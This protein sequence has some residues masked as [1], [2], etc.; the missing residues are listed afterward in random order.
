[1][2][3]LGLESSCDETAFAIYGQKEGLMSHNLFSQVEIHAEFGGVVPELAS[4][5]HIRRV[6]P[7]LNQCLKDAGLKIN[8]IS[9]IGYT[10][11]PGLAGALLVGSTFAKALAYAQSIPAIGVHHLEAHLMAV[12]LEE[13][14]PTFPFLTLLV[15]GGHTLL[16][17]AKELGRYQILGQTLDDALGEAF[18]KT[19]KL[20]NL[21][22][23]G[24]PALEICA[25]MGRP[26][27]YQFP[28]PM[29]KKNNLDFSFSG[30][31]TH[32]MMVYNQSSQKEQDKAD[33]AHAFQEAV[34]DCLWLKTKKAIVQ[35]HSDQLVVA[36]G[37]SAN[38]RIRQKL[39]DL[40]CEVFFP[41]PEF[42]TDNGAM[43]AYLAYKKFFLGQFKMDYNEPI[44]PKWPIDHMN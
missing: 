40:D 32:C 26:N 5:D 12:M 44:L 14:Q 34:T 7:L 42:C 36:G 8:D 38:Q 29:C 24:G 23:P 20:L 33:I 15:S 4:R 28:R 35:A 39:S 18:D 25:R 10:K 43:V 21:G 31:K 37:V 9:A 19:A 30:L 27:H 41:R 22:Y 6:L 17:D 2:Y 16:I 13:K 3:I 11:G 1:M